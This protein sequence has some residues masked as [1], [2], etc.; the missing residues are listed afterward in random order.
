MLPAGTVTFVATDVEGSTRLLLGLGEE[1]YGT[2]LADHRLT[3]REATARHDGVEVDTQ[4][5]SFLLAFASA[6][7]AVDASVEIVA[8]LAPGPISV[9]IGIHTGT[10]TLTDDG[11]VGVDLHRVARIA[12]A[13]HGGQVLVSASTRELIDND[14]LVDLGEYRLRDLAH[15]E[16]IYQSGDVQFPPLRAVRSTNLPVATT[17]L[18]GRV[19]ESATL[20]K[21]ILDVETRLVTLTGP[22]GVGKTRLA[23]KVAT[24]AS[25]SFPDGTYWV[26]LSFVRDSGLILSAIATS[27]GIT[28]MIASDLAAPVSRRLRGK[29]AL[30]VLD[31]LEHLLPDAADTVSGLLAIEGP[32]ILV[33]SRERLRLPQERAWP[34]P[35]LSETDGTNL[36]VERARRTGATSNHSPR[37]SELCTRLDGLPLAIELA[38]ARTTLFTPEQLLERLGRRLDLLT[39][40]HGTDPRQRTLRATIAWSYELLDGPERRLLERCAVFVGGATYEAAAEVAGATPDVLQA[41]IDKSLVRRRDAPSGPRY[42]MLDTIREFAGER[43]EESG[44]AAET[45]AIHAGWYAQRGAAG[46]R[47]A[48]DQDAEWLVFLD[49]ELANMRAGLADSIRAGDAGVVAWF[50]FAL[51]YYWVLRGLG[52]EARSVA[53][54]WLAMDRG[55]LDQM[56]RYAGLMGAGEC[57]RLAGDLDGARAIKA[58]A[59]VIARQ[60][61]DGS[62]YGWLNLLPNALQDLSAV[63]V[64]DGRLDEAEA[65]AS[66]ALAHRV[67]L[68]RPGWTGAGGRAGA[69][70]TLAA[71]R[72]ARGDLSGSLVL[73]DSATRRARGLS[74]PTDVAEYDL[75]AAACEIGLHML[76]A[77]RARLEAT[78]AEIGDSRSPELFVMYI[79][80]GALFGAEG[81]NL[82]AAAK[83]FGAVDRVTLES[84]Y[85]DLALPPDRAVRDRVQVTLGEGAF[86]TAQGVGAN[87][88]D[89]DVLALVEAVVAEWSDDRH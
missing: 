34:V 74:Y 76:P 78:S 46:A 84:G 85:A 66:E 50:L 21:M 42:S 36:F 12:A 28:E 51:W 72:Y 15:P 24:E 39:A 8:G 32:T 18:V 62:V 33:T 71:V 48:R 64:H 37:V 35:P 27:V 54:A 55:G 82:E 22:G 40:P 60:H 10:P 83:L 58:E 80:T 53:K 89:T 43:L 57:L 13:G 4:G 88:S 63:N 65:Q 19:E 2:A 61:P 67:D 77:A 69:E 29:R 47:R 41:L 44:A 45:R 11:Y 49:D 5:D 38:A 3:V 75:G 31:T 56:N 16:R 73:W 9:R 87:L 25:S 17:R 7:R 68:V 6:R 14:E 70:S 20:T 26:P 30:L 52:Y 1:A 86:A 23:L 81:G 59:L 79:R